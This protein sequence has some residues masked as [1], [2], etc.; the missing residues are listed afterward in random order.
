MRVFTG[1]TAGLT[2]S[3]LPIP[4]GPKVLAS[5]GSSGTDWV[6]RTTLLILLL[7][8]E[9]VGSTRAERKGSCGGAVVETLSAKSTPPSSHNWYA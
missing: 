8:S 9:A 5:K 7:S 6:P 4:S 1:A 3:S 2:E